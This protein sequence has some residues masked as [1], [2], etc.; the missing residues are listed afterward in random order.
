MSS[1]QKLP[2]CP[3]EAIPASSKTDPLLAKA[4]PSSDG[5]SASGITRLSKR[6][7]SAGERTDNSEDNKVS[8]GGGG[9]APDTE[10]EVALQLVEQTM[11]RQAVPQQPTEAQGGADIHLQ[12]MEELMPEQVYAQRRQCPVGKPALE[13]VPGRTHV[14]VDR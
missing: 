8:E 12:P 9:C 3:T 4:K 14:P 2:P 11:V 5:S 6:A 10:A 13:Q 1:C 7:L